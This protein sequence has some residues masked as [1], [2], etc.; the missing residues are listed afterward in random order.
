MRTERKLVIVSESKSFIT[1]RDI[2]NEVLEIKNVCI[3]TVKRILRHN[4]LFGKVSQNIQQKRKW[5]LA[6][7]CW[8]RK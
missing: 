2:Q 6:K 3:A 5:C 4:G 8:T 7:K 1:A